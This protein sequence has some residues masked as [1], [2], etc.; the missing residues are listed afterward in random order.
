VIA[1]HAKPSG[2]NKKT[3]GLSMKIISTGVRGGDKSRFPGSIPQSIRRLQDAGL[4]RVKRRSGAPARYTILADGARH[5]LDAEAAKPFVEEGPRL[6]KKDLGAAE[7]GHSARAPTSKTDMPNIE[8]TSSKIGEIAE[9]FRINGPKP[10]L[11]RLWP[12]ERKMSIEIDRVQLTTR[13]KNGNHDRLVQIV[14]RIAE[15]YQLPAHNVVSSIYVDD[16][17]S[18]YFEIDLAD[19]LQPHLAP[20]FVTDL[21]KLFRDLGGYNGLVIRHRGKE[22]LTD[23]SW[24]R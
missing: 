24:W 23:D 10:K 17:R 11:C 9:T 15:M 20:R 22:L 21:R 5:Y 12:E 16:R 14:G 18:E 3:G 7:G 8:P 4:L 2:R 6:R 1:G 13:R 19:A